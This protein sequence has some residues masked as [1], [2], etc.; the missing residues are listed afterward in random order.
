MGIN[1]FSVHDTDTVTNAS[2]LLS[3]Q[4]KGTERS[5]KKD[6]EEI[7][8]RLMSGFGAKRQLSQK[9]QHG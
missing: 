2:Q 7:R 4:R 1:G 8:Q 3:L 5:K 9:V 6:R